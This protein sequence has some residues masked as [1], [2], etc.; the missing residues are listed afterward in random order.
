MKVMSQRILE[1]PR[2]VTCKLHQFGRRHSRLLIWKTAAF[3]LFFLLAG[4]QSNIVLLSSNGHP[5]SQVTY[6]AAIQSFARKEMGGRCLVPGS[7]R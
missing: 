3:W 4:Y 7:R 1:R 2:N 6:I 5:G